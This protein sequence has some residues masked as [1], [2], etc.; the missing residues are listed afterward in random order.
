MRK[1]FFILALFGVSA[2]AQQGTTTQVRRGSTLPTTCVGGDVFIKSGTSAGFYFNIASGTCSWIGP[3]GTGTGLADPGSNGIVKRTSLNTT[4]VAGYADIVSLF[5]SGSCS[6]YLKNDGTCSTAGGSSTLSAGTAAVGDSSNA[7]S[8]VPYELFPHVLA[9]GDGTEA[10]PWIDTTDGN[11]GIQT[12]LDALGTRGGLVNLPAG[13]FKIS[14]SINL[15]TD[16]Q[17]VHCSVAGYNAQPDGLSEGSYGCKLRLDS[18]LTSGAQMIQLGVIGG[19]ITTNRSGG[20]ILQNLYLWGTTAT[21]A[22]T[23]ENN[24]GIIA[25]GYSD[26]AKI[27]GGTISK[28]G[29]AIQ[30]ESPS[31][32][33]DDLLIRE[34]NIAGNG[35]GILWKMDGGGN[36]AWVNRVIA[37]SMYDNDYPAIA[38]FG[39]GGTQDP[40]LTGDH[41]LIMGNV[42][43]RACRASGC[44]SLGSNKNANIYWERTGANFIGNNVL[45]AGYNNL[46]SS[47]VN[48]DGM[49]L[50]ANY[51]NVTGNQFLGQSQ[52]GTAGLR[53]LGSNN[54][55]SGNM[56]RANATDIIVASGAA[57]NLINE[58]GATISDSGTRTV[59][60]FVGRNAGDPNSTGSW[61]GVAKWAGLHIYDTTNAVTYLYLDPSTR[62]QL[63]GTTSLIGGATGSVPYQSAV[64]T[65]TFLA[66]PTTSAHTFFLGW[67]PSGSAIT[68]S[69]VDLGA[70]LGT[71]V[72]GT[73]PIVVTQNS[74]G[75][76]VSCPT[77]GSGSGGT[78]TSINSG[79][80][81][82][83]LALTG[84]M[85]QTCSDT[86]GSGTAQSCSSAVSFTPQ[87][88]NCFVYTT[89][90]A[91]SSTGLTV[92]VNSVGAKSVA[93]PGTTGWTT[94]LLAGMIPANKPLQLCYDGT[95]YNLQGNGTILNSGTSSIS[96]STS[97]VN[98][99]TTYNLT[100]LGT[101][102]W[103]FPG[104]T[105]T[106][107]RQVAALGTLHAKIN[108]CT[109]GSM[110]NS[111]NWVG[112]GNSG[113]TVGNASSTVNQKFSSTGTDDIATSALSTSQVGQYVLST[114]GTGHGYSLAVPASPTPRTLL[115]Y[116]ANFSSTVTLTAHLVDGSASDQTTTVVTSVST[117]QE[118]VATVT[119]QSAT[120]TILNLSVIVTT[121]LGS[122]QARFEAA[123]LQ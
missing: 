19:N 97:N 51:V 14:S 29:V 89:T 103:F 110:L 6:G 21:P 120:N 55:I 73:S 56:L 22:G 66:S 65:T 36:G 38:S 37:N 123:V 109:G 46:T 105:T 76:D 50:N 47:W 84:Y 59:F 79:S 106:T 113:A 24:V 63:G 30:P 27:L 90:T 82:S 88:G 119:Y 81:I 42:I 96:L 57:D 4:S 83:N 28:F 10:S 86:S 69:A 87:S 100:T 43:G 2:F 13:R 17:A 31:G 34:V 117:N 8:S 33:A 62:I 85:P 44:A 122:A 3:A 108:G 95:N 20:N 9:T 23:I 102:D 72:A 92:N 1:L 80:T 104:G 64:N 111:F 94:T 77:C 16:A 52:S 5:G 71:W 45:D 26:Q 114:S 107:P 7:L 39:T 54:R 40:G 91:N 78:N 70:N 49:V 41:M 115:I 11:G 25:N 15:N 67:Q 99:A 53:I 60:N 74:N 101:C 48:A 93:I 112:G 118:W 121:N 61:N 75:I 116:G 12:Q 68:P 32:E 18:S 98:S 35:Y 58:P